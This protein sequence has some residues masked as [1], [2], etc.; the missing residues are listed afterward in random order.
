VEEVL[1]ARE[2]G[3]A[4]APPSVLATL[5]AARCAA[6]AGDVA[7]RDGIL[8][9]ALRAGWA[10]PVG[11]AR[12]GAHVRG[13]F[14]WIDAGEAG[15]VVG[16]GAE[17]CA[18]LAADALRGDPRT[19]LDDAVTLASGDVDAA[20]LAFVPAAREPLGLRA[21]L[22]S[23]AA[24]AGISEAA[25]DQAARYANERIQFG[26][27][28]GAFQA[29][30]HRCADMAVRSEVAWQQTAYA[31]LALREPLADAPFQVASAKALAVQAALENAASNVQV[32]GGYGFTVEYDAQLLV[33]RAHV[34]ERL[35]GSRTEQ[36]ATLLAAPAPI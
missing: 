15:L 16:V 13:R 35:A 36:L 25:R 34:Y 12:L 29:I 8:A 1:L 6:F 32:H 31:A 26:K 2:L 11:E 3:R 7:R 27:P 33:K 4:L 22:L 20:A 18:L 30:K 17:G 21:T 23:A 5:L 10:E 28:I 9:G 14:Q 24:L 19:C